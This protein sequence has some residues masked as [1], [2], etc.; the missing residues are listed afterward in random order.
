MCCLS[1][2]FNKEYNR[3]R[4]QRTPTY[5]DEP[6]L[7]LKSLYHIVGVTGMVMLHN[8]IVFQVFV[9]CSALSLA[10]YGYFYCICLLH[11]IIDNDILQR[12]LRSVTKNGTVVVS[13]LAYCVYL[14][15]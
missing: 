14:A 7:G 9:A 5:S 10:F 8:Y 3:L 13:Q 4:R 11:V 12:V 15:I 1:H 6:L 2:A